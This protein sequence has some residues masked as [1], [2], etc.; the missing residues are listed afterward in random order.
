VG[1]VNAGTLPIAKSPLN[2]PWLTLARSLGIFASSFGKATDIS[3]TCSS[4]V[5]DTSFLGPAISGGYLS[6]LTGDPKVNLINA[7]ALAKESGIKITVTTG[8]VQGIVL[9]LNVAGTKTIEGRIGSDEMGLLEKVDNEIF[10]GGVPLDGRCL[11]FNDAEG[12]YS[13]LEIILA[14]NKLTASAMYRTGG[15]C[16]IVRLASKTGLKPDLKE[17]GFLACRD[18]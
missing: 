6:G 14:K 12:S 4:A 13:K 17:E 3:V 18:F 11:I 8:D 15:L 5:K 7:E 9:K 1:A 10:V 2:R 16:Y